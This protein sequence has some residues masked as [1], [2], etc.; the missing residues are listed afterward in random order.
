MSFFIWN[1][2]LA[3]LWA[4]LWGFS[5]GNLLVGFLLGYLLMSL[6]RRTFPPTSYFFKM[7]QVA[8]FALFFLYELVVA[9]VQ[10]AWLVLNPRARV[11]PA[12]VALP[13]SARTDL[14]ITLVAN[15][16]SL[17]PGTLSLE[18][19]PDRRVLYLHGMDVRDS[20]KFVRRA[21]SG[22]EAR[23]LEVLR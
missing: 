1:V 6:V 20:K 14:E 4:A 15:V 9:N 8:R 2:M 10:I 18:V 7:R 3:V 23:A 16:F 11:T 22:L 5:V 19:S 12:I 13:L 21:K 17:T